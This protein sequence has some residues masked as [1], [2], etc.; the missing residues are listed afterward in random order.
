M[1]AYHVDRYNLLSENQIITLT[2]PEYLYEKHEGVADKLFPDG[3]SKAG[4]VYLS[5]LSLSNLYSIPAT[6]TLGD[7]VSSLNSSARG[8]IQRF[9]E[10][11][12]E[13]IRRLSFQDMPSRFQSFFGTKT[14]EEAKDW[15]GLFTPTGTHLAPI[16]WE[17]EV[18][19]PAIELDVAWRDLDIWDVH[20]TPHY[21]MGNGYS[22]AFKYWSGARYHK[23]MP[24]LLIPLLNSK[25]H[26][27]RRASLPQY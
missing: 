9:R 10:I 21:N 14:L 19:T 20:G 11:E 5:D 12:F 23:P 2:K 26:V 18:C 8:T 22:Y 24:E 16:I 4:S 13:Y 17:V 25:V 7:L 15:R 1:I 6:P 27:L 3:I